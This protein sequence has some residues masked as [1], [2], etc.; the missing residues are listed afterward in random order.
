MGGVLTAPRSN[1]RPVAMTYKERQRII[2]RERLALSVAAYI[3]EC[4]DALQAEIARANGQWP[5][6]LTVPVWPGSIERRA[7]V[8]WLDELA[9][10]PRPNS[11]VTSRQIGRA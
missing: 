1:G 5:D 3:T 8:H 4:D 6:R 7:L 2:E 11:R 10:R 9:A